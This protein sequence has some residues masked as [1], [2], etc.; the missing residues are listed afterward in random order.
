M[1]RTILKCVLYTIAVVVLFLILLPFIFYIPALQQ[2]MANYAT[3]AASQQTHYAEESGLKAELLYAGEHY[4]FLA[5]V[6]CP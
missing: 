1:W 3:H 5:R 4:D 2:G 6:I